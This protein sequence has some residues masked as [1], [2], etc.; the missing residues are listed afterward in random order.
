MKHCR[1]VT[2]WLINEHKNVAKK[3]YKLSTRST[4]ED[5]VVV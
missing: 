5:Q 2:S 1:I 3:G 4:K